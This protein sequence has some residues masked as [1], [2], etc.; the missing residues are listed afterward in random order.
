MYKLMDRRELLG[1]LYLIYQQI[2]GLNFCP[3][4]LPWFAAIL[5]KV[6]KKALMWDG[7]KIV[8]P[9]NAILSSFLCFSFIL[10]ER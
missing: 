5:G 6:S 10:R 9:P 4:Y 8:F 7:S 1:V 3:I 2:S